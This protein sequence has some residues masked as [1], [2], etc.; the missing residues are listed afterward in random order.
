[1]ARIATLLQDETFV[2]FSIAGGCECCA[3]GSR[4]TV[5]PAAP[6]RTRDD[7]RILLAYPHR[8]HF[9]KIVL[10]AI[11]GTKNLTRADVEALRAKMRDAGQ[12][13]A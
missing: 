7:A 4:E 9:T 12:V 10:H 8:V 13:P 5:L 2:I 3:E 6:G 1:M 11:V